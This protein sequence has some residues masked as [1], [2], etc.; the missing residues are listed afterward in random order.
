[1]KFRYPRTAALLAAAC[2]APFLVA[3]AASAD[4]ADP[5]LWLEN[6]HGEKA[7]ATVGK[8]NAETARVLDAMPG[9]EADRVRA[10]A[11]MDD[12]H[13]IA[14]PAQVMGDTVTNLW[15]D[16]KHPKGLWREASLSS[17]LSGKPEWQTLI[18]VDALGKE[19]GKSWIWHGANCLA[20]DY[21]RCLVSLSPGGSDADVMREWD[22]T[23]KSF[24]DGGFTLPE[25]KSTVAWEDADTLLVAT[26]FGKG[27]MTTSGYPFVVKRW[28][29]GTPLSAA[30]TVME[31]KASD[32]GV[33]P[34]RL[35]D[36]D[37]TA[38]N[39]I[40]RGITFYTGE[41]WIEGPDHAFIKTPLPETADLEGVEGGRLFA[42]LNKPLGEIPAGSVVDWAIPDVI[43]GTAGAPEVV[44]TPNARQAVEDVGTTDHHVWIK[45][46]DDVSGRLL[47]MTR[48]AD[49]T[50][51]HQTADLPDKATIT[52]KASA[53][54][55][56]IAFA[57]VQSFLVPPTLYAVD[58]GGK[59]AAVQSLPAKF[60]P[61][62]FT[63]EQRFATSKD[64]TRVPYFLAMRKGVKGPVPALIHAYGGFRVAQ[65]PTYLT[66]EPYRA[67]PLALFWV[68]DGNAYVLA[69]IRGGGEYGPKWHDAALREKRQNAYDD[70]YA[71][72]QD[73]VKRG[74]TARGKIAVSGRSNGGL[75]AG[76]AM[77]QRPDLFGAAIIGSPLLDMKRYSHML[78]GASWMAEYGNPDNPKDWAFI[79]KYSPYQNLKAGVHYPPPFIYLSTEDDRVHPGHARKFTAKLKALGDTV[80]YHEYREGGHSV[81]AA[82][83][84]DA[85]RAAMLHAYLR[86]VLMGVQ[87]LKGP[88]KQ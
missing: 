19:E 84:E 75:M 78:A 14:E 34:R 32:V 52:L 10:K 82:H 79:R 55:Q 53:D 27:T 73:L 2:A 7:L 83:A 71:V 74:I 41:T 62:Q 21:E 45:L 26:D 57:T 88:V 25:A 4:N 8:W 37:G 66:T 24:V 49:G 29:R 9:Y 6:I 11:I 30:Q 72:A 65:T 48:G 47:V 38:Y 80:Y 87:P 76:V 42:F 68:E 54:K 17:Y 77:T 28:K 40:N 15:R 1:M 64:G 59:A 43:A 51:S 50:W 33:F 61:S 18:D 13:Q 63:V 67:G 35:I 39:V 70:L 46:L 60:D 12:E 20:P 3:A 44:F 22:R 85:V 16:A 31:G 56:D 36:S 58:A 81:G 69:N 86:H 23:T 5:Y